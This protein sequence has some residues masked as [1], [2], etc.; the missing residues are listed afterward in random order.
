MHGNMLKQ[1]GDKT[2][3]I[4]F[5]SERNAGLVNDISV[6][7]GDSDIKPSPCAKYIVAWLDF[8]MD[9]ERHVNYVCNSCF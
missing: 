5:T 7:V 8:R 2:E 6:N 9:M 4:V 3:V 1:N